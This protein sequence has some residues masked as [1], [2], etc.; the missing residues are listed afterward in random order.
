MHGVASGALAAEN[1]P[2]TASVTLID[3]VFSRLVSDG[4]VVA[5]ILTTRAAGAK[6]SLCQPAISKHN[7]GFCPQDMCFGSKQGDALIRPLAPGTWRTVYAI[8]VLNC[9][10]PS[11][12]TAGDAGRSTHFKDRNTK[13]KQGKKQL[14]HLKEPLKYPECY[15]STKIAKT[16]KC[17]NKNEARFELCSLWFQRLGNGVSWPSHGS[18]W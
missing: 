1:T 14:I 6:N 2:F 10:H 18:V 17:K 3:G 7:S 16:K 5:A 11:R 13:I 12:Y 4:E 15:R 9:L 8:M